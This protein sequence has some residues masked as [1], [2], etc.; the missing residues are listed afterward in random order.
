[1][2]RWV[3]AGVAVGGRLGEVLIVVVVGSGA[4]VV[5]DVGERAGEDRG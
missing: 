1:M 5:G 4:E 3:V 2:G